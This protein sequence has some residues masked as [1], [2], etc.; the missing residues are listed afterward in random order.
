MELGGLVMLEVSPIFFKRASPLFARDNIDL[1]KDANVNLAYGRIYGLV[2]RNGV[3]KTTFL[4]HLA[5]KAF[6]GVP[7]NL[8]ILHIEQ[9]V[10][11][12]DMT[13]LETVLKTDFER[14]SLLLEEKQILKDESK[15]SGRLT[16]IYQRLQEIDA[17]TAPSRA[18]A[19]LSGFPRHQ[20]NQGEAKT[21]ITVNDQQTTR[22][23]GIYTRNDEKA[24]QRIFWWVANE[25]FSR[26]GPLYS[27]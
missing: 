20:F 25:G 2:G 4:K 23:I 1:S 9:E 21:I 24:N 6:P 26:F 22:R 19:I 27:A 7:S 11:G 5:A 18:S 15:D 3:G 12:S 17:D 8:Q 13:A 16:H 14:E 10:A